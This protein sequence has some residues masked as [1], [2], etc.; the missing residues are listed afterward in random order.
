MNLDMD[1][2]QPVLDRRTTKTR[3]VLIGAIRD[4]TGAV[5]AKSLGIAES[6]FNEWWTKHG[7]RVA[8]LLTALDQ[9]PVHVSSK[10]VSEK[11]ANEIDEYVER[12][13]YWAEIG[14]R[15][16]QNATLKFND[17]EHDTAIHWKA[18]P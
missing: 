15:A 6:T 11:R 7:D 8:L 13:R 16:K 18:D 2:L 14:I 17:D 5:V 10:C 12:L 4:K 9:K 1:T 3:A